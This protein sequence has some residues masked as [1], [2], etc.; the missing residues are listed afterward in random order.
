M[1]VAELLVGI[2]APVLYWEQGHEWLFGDPVRHQVCHH[3][4]VLPLLPAAAAAA[5]SSDVTSG[6]APSSVQA[7]PKLCVHPYSL[8]P[9]TANL[10]LQ[11]LQLHLQDNL[12]LAVMAVYLHCLVVS[13]FP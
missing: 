13:R 3:A 11:N 12:H 10:D 9:G 6:L 1:Q 7:E 2:A 8:R 5:A 4:L